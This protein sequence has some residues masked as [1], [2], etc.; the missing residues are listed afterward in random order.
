MPVIEVAYNPNDFY[1][2]TSGL[3]PSVEVCKT[4]LSNKPDWDKTCCI[5]TND[6]QNTA[7]CPLWND[8][9]NNCYKYEL[10][11]NKE[12]ADLANNLENNN[13]GA[14]ERYNNYKKQYQND[15][16]KAINISAG[17]AIIT[18]LSVYFF[19]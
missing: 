19:K 3:L 5:N 15:I 12:N 6:K 13:A 18:Y 7:L 16:L 11:K 8:A 4:Y 2:A 9:S 14:S 1:Y 10:C 17:I